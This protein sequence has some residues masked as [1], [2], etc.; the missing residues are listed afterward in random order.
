MLGVTVLILSACGSAT[1]PSSAPTT[2]LG[3]VGGP[4]EAP[5]TALAQAPSFAVLCS[6]PYPT[7]ATAMVSVPGL[8]GIDV[9]DAVDHAACAGLRVGL[10]PPTAQ[11]FA[12]VIAQAPAAGAEVPVGTTVTITT[13]PR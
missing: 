9:Q 8:V 12:M 3:P 11:K 4:P 7:T 1:T 5:L 2:G 13:H 6:A 10:Q